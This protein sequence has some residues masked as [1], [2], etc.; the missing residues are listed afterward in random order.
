MKNTFTIGSSTIPGGVIIPRIMPEWI[1][2]YPN[3][4]LRVDVSDSLETYEKVKHGDYELGIIGAHYPDADI[5]YTSVIHADRLVLIANRNHP[6]A[7][8]T[9]IR[10]ED[11]KGQ[12]FIIREEGSGT[13]ATY[14]KALKDA[15]VSLGD[16]NVVA[17]IGSTEGV[18][19]A[20]EAGAGLSVVSEVAVR[21]IANCGDV[22]VL[23]FPVHMTRDFYIITSN[24]KP[25]SKEGKEVLS[26][27]EEMI[28][29]RSVE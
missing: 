6:L 14:E 15:G 20:V 2:R 16:L 19:Q 5:E 10:L 24:R 1:K 25:L 28:E 12:P 13:R 8:K 9:D 11:L 26:L 21:E 22:E 17:E 7:G 27:L 23:D 18:I 3:I 29:H 4:S